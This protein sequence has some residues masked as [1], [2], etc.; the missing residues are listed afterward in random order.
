MKHHSIH[1]LLTSLFVLLL[2]CS[3]TQLGAQKVYLGTVY[4]E[5]SFFKSSNDFYAGGD[6][7]EAD[8]TETIY[9]TVQ[10]KSEMNY[11]LKA[12]K[13]IDHG[14]NDKIL[15][16]ITVPSE[17][18]SDAELNGNAVY[19]FSVKLDA[20]GLK[21]DAYYPD[22]YSLDINA[23]YD[24][25]G[26]ANPTDGC[27]ITIEQSEGGTLIADYM[28]PTNYS[29]VDLHSGDIV[30]NGTLATFY[31]KANEGYTLTNI[32]VKSSNESKMPSKT[33]TEFSR[34]TSKKGYMYANVDIYASVSVSATFTK[35]N[36][37]KYAVTYQD[38]FDGGSLL[39]MHN[40]EEVPSGSLVSEGDLINVLCKTS[41]GYT[42]Q[43]ILLNNTPLS[44][45]KMGG[46]YFIMPSESVTV[47]AVVKVAEY[48][49]TVVSNR[50]R[51]GIDFFIDD[52]QIVSDDPDVVQIPFGAK[53]VCKPMCDAGVVVKKLVV[54]P[55][56]GDITSSMSF[57]MP[58]HNIEVNVEFGKTRA[59]ITLVVNGEGGDVHLTD[60][61]EAE[62]PIKDKSTQSG[63]RYYYTEAGTNVMIKTGIAPN[64]IGEGWKLTKLIADGMDFTQT[65][66]MGVTCSFE[67][68][69]NSRVEATFNKVTHKVVEQIEGK[70]SLVYQDCTTDKLM[71]T[72]VNLKTIPYSNKLKVTAI[73]QK[74]YHLVSL[75]ANEMDLQMME[76]T[77]VVDKD[78]TVK[79]IFEK[80]ETYKLTLNTVGEGKAVIVTPESLDA[81]QVAKGTKV[82]VKGV[83]SDGWKL[84]KIELDGTDITANPTFTV[85][86]DC[87]LT[88]TFIAVKQ[89]YTV[90]IEHP[91]YGEISI[92]GADIT[93]PV[94]EGT[95]LTVVAKPNEHYVL[96][97]LKANDKDIT[98]TKKFV[99]NSNVVVKAE[100]ALQAFKVEIANCVNGSAEISGAKNLG[101]VPYNTELTVVAHPNN[102]YKLASI[103]VNGNDIT[104]TKKFIV[105]QDTKV[106]VLFAKDNAITRISSNSI[107]AMFVGQ[108]LVIDGADEGNEILVYNIR[109]EL[110]YRGFDNIISLPNPFTP[111]LVLMV[112]NTVLKVLK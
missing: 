23:E 86:K 15:T 2:G 95:E 4:D 101:E 75:F 77:F 56:I 51:S 50:E 81:N 57:T 105:V 62:L 64:H 104:T 65:A 94:L 70:G 90:S 26:G 85:E 49:A 93:K 3:V 71:S 36:K 45:N 11:P 14:N 29:D 92:K 108:T 102:G 27:T 13:L 54:S 88:F 9:V 73:P 59:N 76:N 39:L 31:A 30:P 44:Q 38:V 10:K 97:S 6:I 74:G 106:E 46:Y 20:I 100:F 79:A 42:L 53:V 37:Q 63:I 16:T 80:D 18:L 91:Q 69:E 7:H 58:K 110:V 67:A 17:K 28:D 1:L 98:K 99:V 34:A 47:K 43:S 82:T 84:E 111:P 24:I 87:Q 68:L 12:I 96:R 55:N 52:K 78:F 22:S 25:N 35:A 61:F 21:T 112:G 32:Q 107:T 8:Y 103:K 83:P 19:Y 60:K 72:P 109:G 89:S 5:V 33:I 66:Q 48:T 41:E 40:G